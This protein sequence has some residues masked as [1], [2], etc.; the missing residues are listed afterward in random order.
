MAAI[1]NFEKL[2]S[3]TNKL[4][5]G[6]DAEE[7]LDIYY[8]LLPYDP[9]RYTEYKALVSVS[10][11]DSSLDI[12]RFI[13]IA[14]YKDDAKKPHWKVLSKAR[15]DAEIELQLEA[16]INQEKVKQGDVLRIELLVEKRDPSVSWDVLEFK[17][18]VGE[19]I[20]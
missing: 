3:S 18:Y 11:D 14:A 16:S 15:L 20:L 4:N 19:K 6:E 9:S 10:A 5:F 2:L 8:A 17:L 7:G 13:R 12:T 1:L